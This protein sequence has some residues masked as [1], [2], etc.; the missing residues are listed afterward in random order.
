[1]VEILFEEMP[2]QKYEVSGLYHRLKDAKDHV[3]S[4]YDI[5]GKRIT[6]KITTLKGQYFGEG[7]H[8]IYRVTTT[9]DKY[10]MWKR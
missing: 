3:K 4:K 9:G 7:Y 5:F 2:N 8:Q 10:A 6:M 1:M